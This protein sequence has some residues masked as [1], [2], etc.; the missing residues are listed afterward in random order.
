MDYQIEEREISLKRMIFF[1]LHQ[2]RRILAAAM[3]LAVLLG[4]F[5]AVK[6]WNAMSD[7]EVLAQNDKD[8]AL[9]LQQY[10]DEKASLEAQVES[11]QKTIGNQ[12][13][14]ME[15]S[16][17]MAIDPYNFY[18]GTLS[19]CIGAEDTAQTN[20]ILLAYQSALSAGELLNTVAQEMN[21]E[22]KYLR[23]LVTVTVDTSAETLNNLLTVSVAYASREGAQ[24][25][26]NLIAEGVEE[27][28]LKLNQTVGVHNAGIVVCSVSACVDLNVS[29]LQKTE[30]ENQSNQLKLLE[31]AQNQLEKLTQPGENV[32][33]PK[34]VVKSALKYALLGA[35]I[36]VF[37]VLVI[38]CFC[39]V[40]GDKLY[41]GDEL[42]SRFRVTVL[43]DI[44]P[45]GKRF[46]GLDAWL[47][48]VE[49]RS[50]GR[51][52]EYD[53]AAANI[54]NYAGGAGKILVTSAAGI[55][56]SK[57]LAEALEGKTGLELIP[58]GSLLQ[59]PA[60]LENLA[61]CDA[62]VMV[63]RC[64]ISRYS[65]IEAALER[66]SDAGKPLL[67]FVIEEI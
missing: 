58:C 34:A 36:A 44:L 54:R 38:G 7:P 3:V 32:M 41:S 67:G 26:L 40:L 43:A 60:A 27:L 23:E 22:E 12:Q 55:P 52:S 10:Q 5:R 13:E 62:V 19:I 11:L 51:S 18:R 30:L 45:K 16:V 47:N 61:V 35:F 66:V 53:L 49:G 21:M 59:D 1:C 48:R 25:L 20:T 17:L 50:I 14:Y 4:G 57:A 15:K 64:R 31:T 56:A 29:A 6:L 2:W 39:F 28:S 9:A 8:Y 24:Q 63:E 46:R 37:I 42:K 33:T 65:A